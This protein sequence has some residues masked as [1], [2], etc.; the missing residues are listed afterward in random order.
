MKKTILI[1]M[2]AAL[3]VMTGC[4]VQMNDSRDRNLVE[5]SYAYKDFTALEI[6]SAFDVEVLEGDYR[7][8]IE[9][10]DRYL[11]DLKVKQRG[12]VLEIGLDRGFHFSL[13]DM[14]R[15]MKATITMPKLDALEAVG[16]T[17]VNIASPMTF[18][19]DVQITLTGASTLQGDIQT[20]TVSFDL[21]GAATYDGKIESEYLEAEIVGASNMNV[22]GSTKSARIDSVGASGFNGDDFTTGTLEAEA[23]GASSVELEATEEVNLNASGASNIT[24]HGTPRVVSQDSS[25]ASSIDVNN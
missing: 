1:L 5:K 21:A 8:I 6:S 9:V 22:S 3:L 16:A 24:I 13:F 14:G 25:G 17:S 11:H 4:T 2:M 7:V 23:T 15:K 18:G 12:G 19:D 10:D 20:K